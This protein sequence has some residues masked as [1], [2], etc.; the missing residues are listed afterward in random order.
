MIELYHTETEEVRVDASTCDDKIATCCYD[1]GIKQQ[2]RAS[3]EERGQHIRPFYPS[4]A[5]HSPG[6]STTIAG[7]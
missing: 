5:P 3:V 6:T 4:E 7:A 1:Q 2:A